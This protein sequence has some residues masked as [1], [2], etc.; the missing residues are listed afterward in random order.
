MRSLPAQVLVLGLHGLWGRPRRALSA[1]GSPLQRLRARAQ[2]RGS[3]AR[4]DSG[5]SGV[6]REPRVHDHPPRPSG[7][8]GPSPL[9]GLCRD[10]ERVVSGPALALRAREGAAERCPYCHDCLEGGE[11]EDARVVCEG[12]GTSH[13]Q[14]CLAEL[15]GCTVMGCPGGKTLPIGAVEEVR[16]RVRGRLESFLANTRRP[17]AARRIGAGGWACSRCHVPF[18]SANCPGCGHELDAICTRAGHPCGGCGREFGLEKSLG[19]EGE[20]AWRAR[21]R[22]WDWILGGLMVAVLAVCGV[23]FVLIASP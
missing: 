17:K 8:L 11:I 4:V 10:R 6:A 19:D 16:A 9:L 21:S 1:A 23:V 20:A 3:E 14:A 22:R 2:G 5:R 7:R 15:G 18:G 12:C 13:H